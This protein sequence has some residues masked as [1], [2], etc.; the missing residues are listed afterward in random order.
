MLNS[1]KVLRELDED[2]I[3]RANRV[4]V[5]TKDINKKC[6]NLTIECMSIFEKY[7][8]MYQEFVKIKEDAAGYLKAGEDVLDKTMQFIE[9]QRIQDSLK[10]V[11]IDTIKH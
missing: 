6:E 8:D 2:L 4:I 10:T 1:N 5:N 11:P 7:V 9:D 3:S